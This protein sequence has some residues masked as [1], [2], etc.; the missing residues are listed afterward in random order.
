MEEP[1]DK[2]IAVL[3]KRQRGYVLWRQLI[4]MGVGREAINRRVKAGRLI[5]VYR[6]IYAVGHVPALPQDRA[7]GALLACGPKAVLSHGTAATVY[8]IYRRWDMP[9]EVTAP[10]LRRRNGI[11]AHRGR[12]THDDTTIQQGLRVTS[13]A[14]TLLD[15]APRL[16]DKQLRRGLNK[17]RLSH[18][19]TEEQLRDVLERFPHHPAAQRL[20]ALAGMHRGATRSGLEDKFADFCERWGLGQPRLNEKINGREVDAY[21]PNER[22][23][24]EVDGYDVH[25]GRV[26]FEDDR[27][28][29]AAMLA[30][31]LP[32]VRV[33][34]ERMDNDPQREAERLRRILSH[35]GAAAR[36]RRRAA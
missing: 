34:E 27:D 1:T 16:T 13:P 35:R 19:L 36:R 29:D 18:N 32:T 9:F 4:R 5:R 24:V 3:A 7:Y 26:S 28:R 22:L 11:R 23:I 12:L 17:L 31:D 10:G 15:M 20:R 8:G 14:R 6:G 2:K 33:T 30:L 21:F 25:S